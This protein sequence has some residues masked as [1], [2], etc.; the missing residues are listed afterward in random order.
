ML[1][2]I[3][4]GIALII[5]GFIA[6]SFYPEAMYHL[7]WNQIDN[8]VAASREIETALDYVYAIEK[9]FESTDVWGAMS[10]GQKNEWISKCRAKGVMICLSFIAAGVITFTIP[11]KLKSKSDDEKSQKTTSK[12]S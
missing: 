12:L 1:R 5:M 11:V 10:D 2:K 8:A 3:V 6:Y 7:S 4:V 9:D